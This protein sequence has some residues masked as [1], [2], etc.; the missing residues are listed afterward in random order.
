MDDGVALRTLLVQGL[1]L[2]AADLPAHG[3]APELGQRLEA[4][5][6]MPLAAFVGA[7]LP[8]GARLA[9]HVVASGLSLV[10][11]DE[12]TLLRAPRAG[13]DAA[14]L[15]RARELRGTMLVVAS[16]AALEDAGDEATL[17]AVLDD[18]ARA[19]RAMGAI[20]GVHEEPRRLPLLVG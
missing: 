9:V 11:E 8:R 3:R 13:V 17:A 19:G 1:P 7:E 2:V 20:V 16:G 18:A 10:G 15:A 5:G 12:T 14:W 4:L 6:L